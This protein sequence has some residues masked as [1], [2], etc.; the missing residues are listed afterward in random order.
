MSGKRMEE[1]SRK[2]TNSAFEDNGQPAFPKALFIKI[3]VALFYNRLCN[4]RCICNCQRI[5]HF[6]NL[7]NDSL[8][9]IVPWER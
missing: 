5:T 2:H 8:R 6:Q 7:L 4:N 3:T 1:N 9:L